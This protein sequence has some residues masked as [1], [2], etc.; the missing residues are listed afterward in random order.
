MPTRRVDRQDTPAQRSARAKVAALKR[1][2][3][4]PDQ[5]AAARDGKLAMFERAVDPDEQLDPEERRR[6]GNR[7]FRAWMTDLAYQA[8]RQKRGQTFRVPVLADWLANVTKKAA[9]SQNGAA[10]EVSD[11]ATSP[12]PTRS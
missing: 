5:M 1:H 6:R 3:V 10:Q 7:L 4:A 8:S 2:S 12:A 11:A 9:P